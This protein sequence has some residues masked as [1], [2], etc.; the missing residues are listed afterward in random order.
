[1]P[2]PKHVLR[3]SKGDLKE[4]EEIFRAKV[5]AVLKGD[6]KIADQRGVSL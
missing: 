4:L 3:L 1:L 6:A 5:L 2:P